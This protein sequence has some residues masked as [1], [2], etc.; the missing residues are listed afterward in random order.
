MKEE[1]TKY[2]GTDLNDATFKL[3]LYINKITD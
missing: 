1:P 2:T 3:K